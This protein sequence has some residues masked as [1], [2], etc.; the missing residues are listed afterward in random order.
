MGLQSR[1]LHSLG[2]GLA[3][4]TDPRRICVHTQNLRGPRRSAGF[5]PEPIPGGWH[6]HRGLRQGSGVWGPV[7][8]ARTVVRVYSEPDLCACTSALSLGS[9]N[10]LV[11]VFV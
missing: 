6:G 4:P 8:A 10:E 2:D 11:F 9:E 5:R 1:D 3:F 7:S